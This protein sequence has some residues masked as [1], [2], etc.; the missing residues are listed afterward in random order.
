M[1]MLKDGNYQVSIKTKIGFISIFSDGN[2]ITS[3]Q[4]DKKVKNNPD[5]L[6][7]KTKDILEKY[8]DGNVVNFNNIK[9]K[10]TDNK[11]FYEYIKKIPYGKITSYSEIGK[12]LNIHPRKV[13]LLLANNKIPIIIP[14]HRVIYKNG[15]LGGFNAH[16]KW[17][18]FLLQTEGNLIIR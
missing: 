4:F 5:K 17:K 16:K 15:K 9:I 3:L 10:I 13:G 6:L 8:L 14:C 12:H 1:D 2:S 7:L 18:K 11:R